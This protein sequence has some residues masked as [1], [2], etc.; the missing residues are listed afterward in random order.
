M[1]KVGL[2]WDHPE[3]PVFFETEA[4][5]NMGVQRDE[6]A[7]VR[8]EVEQSLGRL[9]I[10]CIDLVESALPTRTPPSRTPWEPSPAAGRGQATG[11]RRL[12]LSVEQ[13]DEAAK[14]SLPPARQ[15]PAALQPALPG[16]REG[17]PA[18]GREHG[19]GLLT[20]PS[21]AG[22]AHGQGRRQPHLRGQRR[23]QQE[24]GVL[25]GQPPARAGGPRARRRPHREGPRR[26]PGRGRAGG[27]RPTGVTSVL[28]GART[29]AGRGELRRRRAGPR[30]RG[31]QCLDRAPEQDPARTPRA[32]GSRRRTRAAPAGLR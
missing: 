32:E 25:E 27:R 28:V 11:H 4:E 10:D 16:H 2:R 17:R 20:L 31:A 19:V 1:T 21:R 26:D 30:S 8:H 15:R 12:E 18:L 14:F 23:P 7:S 3:A 6:P 9:G 22:S 29:A 24:D 5:G 13:L